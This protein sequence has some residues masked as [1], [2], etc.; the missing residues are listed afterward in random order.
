MAIEAPSGL[1]A[2]SQTPRNAVSLAVVRR[3]NFQRISLD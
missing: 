1:T 3:D 2:F